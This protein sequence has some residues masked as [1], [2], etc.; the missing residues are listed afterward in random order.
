M[1]TVDG[2]TAELIRDL[3]IATAEPKLI[4]VQGVRD[5]IAVVKTNVGGAFDYKTV[6][7]SQYLVAPSRIAHRVSFDDVPSFLEYIET[8]KNPNSRIFFDQES[9]TFKGVIDYST[10]D[11]A[12]WCVHIASLKLKHSEEW[13]LWFTRDKKEYGQIG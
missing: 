4:H 11:A 9:A 6:D 5:G 13:G 3:A 8:F 12:A 7:L 2:K 10:K 1:E